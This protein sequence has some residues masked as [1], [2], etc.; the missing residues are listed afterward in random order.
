MREKANTTYLRWRANDGEAYPMAAIHP[1]E[2]R[3][4]AEEIDQ[5]RAQVSELLP[6]ALHSAEEYGNPLADR[7]T[8]GAFGPFE[9]VSLWT[10]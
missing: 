7:I 5:L 9:E 2:L 1:H 3:V 8:A 6:W 10:S 4:A